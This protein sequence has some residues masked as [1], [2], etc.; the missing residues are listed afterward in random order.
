MGPKIRQNVRTA[1]ELWENLS[2][3]VGSARETTGPGKYPPV[4]EIP[5]YGSRYGPGMPNWVPYLYPWYPF[6]RHCGFTRT[7]VQAYMSLKPPELGLPKG[8]CI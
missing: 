4:P 6:V 8:P 5:W 3:L 7:L 2:D 1:G